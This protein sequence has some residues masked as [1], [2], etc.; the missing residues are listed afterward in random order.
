MFGNLPMAAFLVWMARG[1]MRRTVAAFV[2]GAA[3][4]EPLRRLRDAPLLFT[5]LGQEAGAPE[6]G[7]DAGGPGGESS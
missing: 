1:V 4:R 2:D 6:D 5:S 3:G 7:D